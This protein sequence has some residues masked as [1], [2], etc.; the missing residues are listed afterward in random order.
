MR[1]DEMGWS[2]NVN[3]VIC[4][5]NKKYPCPD[6]I[7]LGTTQIAKRYENGDTISFNEYFRRYYKLNGKSLDGLLQ[8]YSYYDYYVNNN[9]IGIPLMIDFRVFSFNYKTFDFCTLNGYDLH[10][11]PP[12]DSYWGVNYQEKWTWEKVF[13]YA[14]KIT[15]C[16]RIPGFQMNNI[17]LEDN[18]LF[19]SLCQ[20]MEIPFFIEDSELGIKKCGFRDPEYINKLSIIKKFYENHYIDKWIDDKSGE[21]WKLQSSENSTKNFSFEYNTDFTFQNGMKYDFIPTM[22]HI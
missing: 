14:E 2:K 3:D 10:Y 17:K 18:K 12:Y 21:K 20:A 16:T 4:D 19:I 7:I 13:E 6:L 8:K 11:P 5:E 9:W 22:V 15:E 1:I